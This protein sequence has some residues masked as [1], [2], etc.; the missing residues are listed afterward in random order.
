M[1]DGILVET[2]PVLILKAHGAW[3]LQHAAPLP[4]HSWPRRHRWGT[5]GECRGQEHCPC[6]AVL[7]M[8]ESAGM[9]H[10]RDA[11][12]MLGWTVRTLQFD[13]AQ[14]ERHGHLQRV[15]SRNA[16]RCLAMS[17]SAV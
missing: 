10:S 6:V 1:K 14:G 13:R 15:A 12:P 5:H 11:I 17:R 8:G 2:V 4:P 16:T 9:K 7:S 3:P